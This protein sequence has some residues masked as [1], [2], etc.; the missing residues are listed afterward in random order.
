MGGPYIWIDDI[1]Y[2][3]CGGRKIGSRKAPFN[4]ATTGANS[5]LNVMCA[6]GSKVSVSV[7]A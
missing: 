1:T 7:S 3:K 5:E 4:I 6:M 2:V